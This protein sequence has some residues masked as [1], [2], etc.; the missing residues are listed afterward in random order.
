MWAKKIKG[1][2]K[3]F[4]KTTVEECGKILQRPDDL[5]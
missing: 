2:L 3:I 1:A 5:T 4:S